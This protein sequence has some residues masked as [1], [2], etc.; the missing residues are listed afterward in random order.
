MHPRIL[1]LSGSLRAASY[2]TQLVRVAAAA[3]RAAG[4]EVTEI[5]L[6]DYPLPVFS[7]DLEA[8]EG[9]PEHASTL[10]AMFADADGLL[11]SSPEYNSSV[12]AA[13]KNVIDWISRPTGKDEPPLIAFNGKVAGLMSA[14]PGGLGGMRGLVHLRAIL[15]NIR[16]I[17]LPD[18]VAVSA[19]HDAF[20]EHG[21]LKDERKRGQIAGIAE[22]VVEV[23]SALN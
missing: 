7:E 9:M 23:C 16:V 20:D 2:N 14:S 6:R 13:L 5:E 21:A 22:R 1:A 8:I 17:V 12:T 4:A 18:Q 15:G 10:K 11:I 19:A 3:A